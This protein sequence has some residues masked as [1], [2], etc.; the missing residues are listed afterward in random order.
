MNRPSPHSKLSNKWDLRLHGLLGFSDGVL[1]ADN[2]QMATV[3]LLRFS[4]VVIPAG[5]QQRATV[6]LQRML[7]TSPSA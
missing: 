2:Q 6:H 7:P 1:S 5:N 3:H 4:D